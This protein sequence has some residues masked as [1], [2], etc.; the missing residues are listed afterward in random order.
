MKCSDAVELERLRLAA[1]GKDFDSVEYARYIA[2]L[3]NFAPDLI[4]IA[5]EICRR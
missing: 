2:A 5:L 3:Y 4:K 1:K